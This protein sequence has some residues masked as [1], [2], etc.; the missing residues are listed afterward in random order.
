[1]EIQRSDCPIILQVQRL[2]VTSMFRVWKL[3]SSV[4]SRRPY[5]F[6]QEAPHKMLKCN[7]HVNIFKILFLPLETEC[8][9]FGDI[10]S[11]VLWSVR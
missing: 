8:V 5:C 2:Q 11:L 9:G 6:L 1:M 7:H 4:L 3:C 10:Y